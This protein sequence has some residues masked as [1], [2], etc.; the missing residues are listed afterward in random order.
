MLARFFAVTTL[1]AAVFQPA[2]PVPTGIVLQDGPLPLG[3]A[4]ASPYVTGDTV[5]VLSRR[6]GSVQ[7]PTKQGPVWLPAA[8][9]AVLGDSAA[10]AQ[11]YATAR[12]Y[13]YRQRH[14]PAIALY[15]QLAAQLPTSLYAPDALLGKG[16]EA[17]W[18][19]LGGDIKGAHRWDVHFKPRPDGTWQYDG[20]AYAQILLQYPKS[21][22]AEEALYGQILTDSEWTTP[23]S[24][25]AGPLGERRRWEFFLAKYP[26]STYGPAVWLR[27]SYLTLAAADLVATQHPQIASGYRS[28]ADAR[29]REIVRLHPVSEMAARARRAIAF[30]QGGG[31]VAGPGANWPFEARF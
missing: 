31:H 28:R 30:L 13:T 2:G 1:L 15:H 20:A 18:L 27:W 29:L 10:E 25:A 17:V 16:R 7:V 4:I 22:V 12:D 14:L 19:A 11:L 23:W 8:S 5:P 3:S 9:V 24:N 26:R 6:P 21:P